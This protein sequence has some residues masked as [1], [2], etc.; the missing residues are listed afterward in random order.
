MRWFP[1][2]RR[3]RRYHRPRRLQRAK[4][5]PGVHRRS[6]L[7]LLNLIAEIGVLLNQP[8]QLGLNE[9]EEG[10]NLVLVVAPLADWRLTE[11]DVV[12]VGGGQ[13]HR[14]TSRT[15]RLVHWP[16]LLAPEEPHGH[17]G[18]GTTAGVRMTTPSNRTTTAPG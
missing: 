9:F 6:A 7:L 2:R 12:N 13:R 15:P 16:G 8:S 4:V 14:V 11:R 5:A 3:H 10:I 17:Y 18:L 1:H